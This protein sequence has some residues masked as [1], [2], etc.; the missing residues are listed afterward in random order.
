MT[1]NCMQNGDQVMSIE[2]HASRIFC[3]MVD[4]SHVWSG[5]WDKSIKIWHARVC[6]EEGEPRE[7]RGSAEGVP[8]EC[9]GSAEGVP[10][11]RESESCFEGECRRRWRGRTCADR[12]LGLSLFEGT[13]RSS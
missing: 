12:I 13:H 6:K 1:Y 11:E 4:G 3:L 8:R 5:S 9:R 2:A 7:C 10:R